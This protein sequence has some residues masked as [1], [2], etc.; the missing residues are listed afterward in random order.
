MLP[1]EPK[2][3]HG[4]ET[5]LAHILKLFV[6][7]VPRIAILGAGGMGKSTL[8]RACLHHPDLI[9]KYQDHRFFVAC[10]SAS[11]QAEFITIVGSHLGLKPGKSLNRQIMHH[12]SHSPPCL[13]VLDNLETV[14]EP[15]SSRKGVEEFLSHLTDIKHLALIVSSKVL[16]YLTLQLIL[17]YDADH[18]ARSWTAC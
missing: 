8:A 6:H 2:I 11:T 4:R 17:F 14:W 16:L 9:S 5:E 15:T 10:E 1:P 18:N 12:F 7:T 13:L 3:L